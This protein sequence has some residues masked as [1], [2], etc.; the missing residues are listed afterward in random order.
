MYVGNLAEERDEEECINMF[1][2]ERNEEIKK[3]SNVEIKE[4]K[5]KQNKETCKEGI[6]CKY[7]RKCKFI[8]INELE[9]T[10]KYAEIIL[11]TILKEEALQKNGT[12][13]FG[14][15]IIVEEISKEIVQPIL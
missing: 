1:E 8:H 4:K 15:S 6:N 7:G 3:V 10:L 14:K 9:E 13:I 2:L 11:P 5:R 12:M